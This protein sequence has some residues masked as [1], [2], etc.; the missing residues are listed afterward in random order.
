MAIKKEL[1]FEEYL[2]KLELS[3]ECLKSDNVSLEEALKS[4]EQGI[5][6]Y[7]KCKIILNDAKQKIETYSKQ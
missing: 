5:D 1:S 7:D 6:Y 2:E 4:F 3:A